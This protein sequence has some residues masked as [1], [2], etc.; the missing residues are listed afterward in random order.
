M[1]RELGIG[2]AIVVV[3]VVLDYLAFVWKIEFMQF[4]LTFLAG[5]F[6][7][8]V[9]QHK[10]QAESEKKSLGEEMPSLCEIVSTDPY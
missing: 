3:S 8:Y 9:V 6:S 10:L 1:D 2:I 4:V 5:S 7:T